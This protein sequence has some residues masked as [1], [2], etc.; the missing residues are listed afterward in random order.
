M[1]LNRKLTRA[2]FMAAFRDDEVLNSLSPDDRVEIF[3]HALTGSSDITKKL[4][5]ELLSDYEVSNLE[6]VEI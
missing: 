2:E 5:D 4:L 3:S 6:I 1:P